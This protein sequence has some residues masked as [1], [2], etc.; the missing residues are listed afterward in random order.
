MEIRLD[1]LKVPF[2][3]DHTL[4]CGQLF[5]WQKSGDW[6]YGVV[7]DRV[8]KIKQTNDRL[9]FQTSGRINED[10]IENYFRLGEDLPFILDQIS[11]DEYIRKAIE[12]FHGLRISRQEPWECLI[13]YICA[14]Y[15]NIPAIKNMIFQ[16]SR[17]FGH[18]VS[19]NGCC[20][21]TFPEPAVL[22][23]ASVYE[24]RMCKLGFRAKLVRK[25]A[26]K[27]DANDINWDQLKKIDYETAKTEL[28]KVAGVGNKVADCV[29]L[30]SLE[31]L[32]AFP[33]D[34][35]IRRVVGTHYLDFFNKS[36]AKEISSKKSLLKRTYERIT[37]FARGYFGRYAGYAQE[38]LFHYARCC[39]S[40]G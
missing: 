8:V 22:A 13:S 38:Y 18:L 4:E 32:E 20:V 37:S 9:T 35:W 24:L 1:S 23:K 12:R 5:R 30:F 6:W 25:A 10:F 19:H 14:T 16:L 2:S 34:V 26:R 29:L 11:K 17:R 21:Y 39:E 3:L 36:V 31:K 40:W 28:Q 7:R 33:V 15:M 27:I